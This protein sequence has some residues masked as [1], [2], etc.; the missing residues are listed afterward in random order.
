M[1][2]DH[3]TAMR[4]GWSRRFIQLTETSS[5]LLAHPS[6]I[7]NSTLSLCK[8]CPHSPLLSHIRVHCPYPPPPSSPTFRRC[9]LP[10]HLQLSATF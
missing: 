6:G 2:T 10:R 4:V 7:S 3:I 8:Y 9:T 1:H 5:S